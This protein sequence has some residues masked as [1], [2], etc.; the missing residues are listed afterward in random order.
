MPVPPS[1]RG[2]SPQDDFDPGRRALV[3]N[4]GV[5]LGVAELAPALL[6]CRPPGSSSAEL[7]V[8]LSNSQIL[9]SESKEVEAGPPLKIFPIK[10]ERLPASRTG[11]RA[12]DGYEWLYVTYGFYNRGDQN[13]KIEDFE[14]PM[15]NALINGRIN[16]NGQ[17]YYRDDV[18]HTLA[19][20]DVMLPPGFVF[21]SV[22]AEP[23]ELG[24]QIPRGARVQKMDTP[25]F[26]ELDLAN[27]IDLK[28][29]RFPTDRP[30]SAFQDYQGF[31]QEFSGRGTIEFSNII[32]SGT[33]EIKFDNDRKKGNFDVYELTCSADFAS[34]LGRPGSFTL[35]FGFVIFDDFGGAWVSKPGFNSAYGFSSSGGGQRRGGRK[36][37]KVYLPEGFKS[38]KL[39]IYGSVNEI[40]NLRL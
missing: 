1:E 32:K 5:I 27:T 35:R 11:I 9:G 21:T 10:V 8:A 24:F 31:S 30:D 17:N 13:I 6:A 28:Q 29:F 15:G 34:A 14:I 3:R 36:N 7:S 20:Y 39:F 25:V 40:F 16:I 4:I 38:G 19:L 37:I 2:I 12:K 26:G 23:H 22:N 18:Q 33:E